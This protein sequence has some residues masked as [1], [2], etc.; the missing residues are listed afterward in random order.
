MIKH[1]I[2]YSI[3]TNF[4]KIYLSTVNDVKNMGVRQ[5][6]EILKLVNS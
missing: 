4:F 3:E 6:I 2:F 1:Q 5:M